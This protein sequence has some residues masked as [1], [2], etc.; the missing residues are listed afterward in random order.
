M[1]C[2]SL[3]Y[4]YTRKQKTSMGEIP[5]HAKHTSTTPLHDS[6]THSAHLPYTLS[7][8]SVMGTLGDAHYEIARTQVGTL[9]ST[10]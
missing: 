1:S 3:L 5:Q 10:L 8:V 4:F 6:G 7:R 2:V 9:N